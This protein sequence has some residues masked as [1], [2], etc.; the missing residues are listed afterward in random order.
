MALEAW[1]AAN[2]GVYMDGHEHEDVVRYWQEIFLPAMAKY[3]KRMT[4]YEGPDLKK[5]EPMLEQGE[6]QI[7]AQSHDECCFHA[8]D[9]A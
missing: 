8:K 2:C 9:E 4:W 3:K 7:I 5:I 1:L 6:H